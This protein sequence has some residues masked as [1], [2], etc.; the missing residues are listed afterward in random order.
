MIPYGAIIL[1]LLLCATGCAT[2]PCADGEPGPAVRQTG[3]ARLKSSCAGLFRVGTPG[4]PRRYFSIYGYDGFWDRIVVRDAATCNA[5]RAYR[6]FCRASGSRYSADF[7][8]GFCSAYVNYAEGFPGTAPPL[9]PRKYWTAHFRTPKGHAQAADWFS[10]YEAGMACVQTEPMGEY[11]VVPAGTVLEHEG[12]R[13][14]NRG[15]ISPSTGPYVPP[16]GD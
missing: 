3:L 9:P 12:L 10:G 8:D 7:R 16:H 5:R 15:Y 4:V 6:R 1:G 13:A 14:D 2:V 11:N